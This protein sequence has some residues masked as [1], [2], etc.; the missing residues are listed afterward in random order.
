MVNGSNRREIPSGWT[1]HEV[2]GQ[3]KMKILSCHWNL[4]ICTFKSSLL[5]E[6][7]LS[8]SEQKIKS[9][10]APKANH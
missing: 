1:L 4:K 3:G 8:L 9:I 6:L 7:A 5:Q 10:Q 2:A